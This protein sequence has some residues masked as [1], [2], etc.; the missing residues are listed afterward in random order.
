MSSYAKT[1]TIDKKIPLSKERKEEAKQKLAEEYKKESK[2]VKGIFKNL[3]CKGGTAQ[4]AWRK[5]P[6]DDVT[7]FTFEDG[8]TYDIPLCLAKHI[9]NDCCIQPHEY[10]TNLNGDRIVSQNREKAFQR[11]EFTSTEYM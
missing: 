11:Y 4:I 2:I 7:L 9:N 10:L 3:E 8:K 6:Q 1:I 5:F